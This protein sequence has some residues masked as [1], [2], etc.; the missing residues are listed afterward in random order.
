MVKYVNLFAGLS[1]LAILFSVAIPVACAAQG[2]TKVKTNADLCAD[3]LLDL[4]TKQSVHIE[5]AEAKGSSEKNLYK[6]AIVDINEQVTISAS[7]D[8]STLVCGKSADGNI[9]IKDLG[10]DHKLRDI[11]IKAS[12]LAG[13]PGLDKGIVKITHFND[14]GLPDAVWIQQVVNNGG[15]VYIEAVPFSEVI[16]GGFVGDYTKTGTLDYQTSTAF[17]LGTTFDASSVNAIEATV[18]PTYTETSPYDI[19]TDGLVGWWKFDENTGTNVSDSSGNGNHGTASGMTWVDGKYNSAGSFDGVN[20][21]VNTL[22][23][24]G[25]FSTG[26]FAILASVNT[27]YSQSAGTYGGMIVN[28]KPTNSLQIP[29]W[30]LSQS[31]SG[32]IIAYIADGTN[33]GHCV[34]PSTYND[35]HYHNVALVINRTSQT[36]CI[37]VDGVLAAQD[38]GISDV[39]S[40]HT[41]AAY[42]AIGALHTSSV[43]DYVFY[44]GSIDNVILYNRALS[45]NEIS[46]ICYD[47]IRDLKLKTNSNTGYSDEIDESGIV[48]IPYDSEDSDITSLAAYVPEN[49][50]IG[51]VTVRDY[52]NTVT[53]FEVVATVGYTE[54]TTLITETLTDE[55]YQLVIRHTPGN[56]YT[57]DSTVVY[58]SDANAILSSSYLEYELTS[59][60]PNAVLSFNPTTLKWTITTGAITAGTT[61]I[62]NIIATTEGTEVLDVENGVGDSF[63][64][65]FP[66]EGNET[67]AIGTSFTVE[68]NSE[69]L[70]MMNGAD[71]WNTTSAVVLAVIVIMGACLLLTYVRK[72]D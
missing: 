45:V 33:V 53:P 71:I 72:V 24:T 70:G 69:I 46:A 68:S 1:I 64:E 41:T 42:T 12:D 6:H 32:V 35:G 63:V 13:M 52:T 43:G 34:T 50:T 60:N 25:D 39:G 16:I 67:T 62:Y 40:V 14:A 29:G 17:S 18:T 57:A 15:Y 59:T 21:I 4:Q 38:S 2:E 37:Y 3:R 28:K 8:S 56:D 48:S 31:S 27:T 58:T 54:D 20:D 51:G 26:S 55:S 7:L 19:P 61:Y 11:R 30:S 47:S 5:K 9:R 49:V 10:K 66:Q 65:T 44:K 36:M 22:T 23:T